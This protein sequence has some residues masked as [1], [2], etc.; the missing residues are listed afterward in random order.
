[1][2]GINLIIDKQKKLDRKPIQEM[3]QATRHRGPDG[4]FCDVLQIASTQVFLGHHRLKIIDLSDQANQPF[5]SYDKHHVLL[6]NGEIYND[7]SLRNQLKNKYPFRTQSDTEVLLYWLIEQGMDGV[8]QL[9][10]MFAFVWIDLQGKKVFLGRDSFGIKPLYYY[11]DEQYL[12][13][14]SEIKGILNAN[15]TTPR[16]NE[17]QISHYLTYRFAQAPQTFYQDIYQVDSPMVFD[18]SKQRWAKVELQNLSL[19]SPEPIAP[20]DLEAL[21]LTSVEQQLKA[22]VPMGIFLSGGIDSTLLLSMIQELGIKSFPSFSLINDAREANFGTY[23]YHYARLAAKQFGSSHQE[24][25]VK[26]TDFQGFGTWVRSLDQPIGDGALFL[27]D[28]LAQFAQKSVKAVLSGAG[29]DEL[30]AGY[31]R[32]LAFYKYLKNQRLFNG[33]ATGKNLF[34]KLPLDGFAHPW[35]KKMRLIRKLAQNIDSSPATTFRN[36]TQL[37][38]IPLKSPLVLAQCSPNPSPNTPNQWLKWCLHYDQ[39]HF[40]AQDV[41]ALTDARSMQHG[42]EVRVPYLSQALYHQLHRLNPVDLLQQGRKSLLKQWLLKRGGKVFVQRPKEG[43]GMPFGYWLSQGKL[44]WIENRLKSLESPI[45]RWVHFDGFQK[46]LQL[47]MRQK[48]DYTSE[49][50]AVFLLNQWLEINFPSF[51]S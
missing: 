1:M 22:D 18:L 20:L 51:S 2:C 42:L 27:T 10:G 50:W 46:I 6:F 31:N 23:D 11:N 41:L 7:A 33:L 29:A 44:S 25:L 45:Y 12:L 47:H 13:V 4:S 21:L 40:L 38:D 9:E 36:F 15:L 14:S 5:Y 32:H 49:I 39:R 3:N 43:F 28:L 48:R 34:N 17:S 19:A 35:R 16:L 26:P 30:F 37:S 24:L 8:K